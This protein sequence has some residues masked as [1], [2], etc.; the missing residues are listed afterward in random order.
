MT[1]PAGGPF[2]SGALG[3]GLPDGNG[4]AGGSLPFQAGGAGGGEP[5]KI[6]FYTEEPLATAALAGATLATAAFGS[7]ALAGSSCNL[8]AD[9]V[10]ASSASV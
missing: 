2:D 7:L 6:A 8:I 9:A 1:Y 3:G 4:G 5:G 10:T